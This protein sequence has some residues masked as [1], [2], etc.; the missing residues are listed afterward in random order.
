MSAELPPPRWGHAGR[1]IRRA[2]GVRLLAPFCLGLWFIGLFPGRLAHAALPAQKLVPAAQ[3]AGGAGRSAQ[4]YKPNV[5]L[6]SHQGKRLHF[7]DDLISGKVVLINMMFTT[8]ASICPPM[9]SNLVRVQKLLEERLGPRLG[10]NLW[11]KVQMISITVDP[12]TDTVEVLKA[13]AA[14]YKV[15][16]GWLFLTGK[17]EDIDA[18]LAKLG[19]SDPDKNRHSG[20][21]IIGDDAS[22]SFRKV[23]AMSDPADIVS[24]VEKLLA[25]PTPPLAPRSAP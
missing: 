21:L 16:P 13:Y 12:E 9:T 6:L 18:L 25:K 15:G 1:G 3:A 8:C 5:E 24:S 7:Y 17:K 20:M 22:H 11:K 14:R 10:P 19:S 4:A 23:F 2:L